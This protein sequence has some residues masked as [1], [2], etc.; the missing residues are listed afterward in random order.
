[1][2]LLQKYKCLL[3]GNL[4]VTIISLNTVTCGFL[5][6]KTHRDTF[7]L[8]VKVRHT[9]DDY[10]MMLLHSCCLHV[11]RAFLSLF[12]L[13][14]SGVATCYLSY[15]K[16]HYKKPRQIWILY[17]YAKVKFLKYIP[18]KDPKNLLILEFFRMWPYLSGSSFY[19][20]RGI[21]IVITIAIMY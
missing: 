14:G 7:L 2:Y 6:T 13:F 10:T 18:Q 8:Q 21:T 15:R 4:P 3:W 16:I 5:S 11:K 12:I 17:S 19:W 1:M 20:R 9:L